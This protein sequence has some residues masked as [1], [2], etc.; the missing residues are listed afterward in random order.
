MDNIMKCNE[1][2]INISYTKLLHL[3]IYNKLKNKLIIH[4]SSQYYKVK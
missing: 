4:S 2:P 1:N 3:N